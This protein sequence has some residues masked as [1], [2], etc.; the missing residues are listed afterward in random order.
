MKKRRYLQ[1]VPGEVI[2]LRRPTLPAR[3]L[4][5]LEES[6]GRA[7]AVVDPEICAQFE[8]DWTGRFRG[9]SAAV[10]RPG[11]TAEV[12]EVLSLCSAAG[13]PVVPQGGNTGLV[14]GGVPMG[15]E[16]V[17]SLRR[18]TYIGE[19]DDSTGQLTVG[20]GTTLGA[21]QQ[22]LAP[23]GLETTMDL[24]SRDSATLGGM[25]ATNAGGLQVLRNGSMRSNVTGIEV[26]LADGSVLSQLRGLP[27]DTSGYD[28]PS[29]VVGSEG[30]L[31]VITQVRLRV[32][33]A[34]DNRV[35]ALLGTASLHDAERIASRLRNEMENL[36]SAE[37]MER[38]TLLLVAARHGLPALFGDDTPWVL[39]IELSGRQAAG[40]TT[41][42]LSE[43]LT[44]KVAAEA[45][46]ITDSAIGSGGTDLQRLWSYRE[47]IPETL[48]ALGTVR[49]LDVSIP[50]GG[51]PGFVSA[52][53][54]LVGRIAPSARLHVFGHLLDGNLHLNLL[55]VSE[56]DGDGLD[57]SVLELAVSLGGSIG[58]EHGIG[59]AKSHLLHLV[60]SPEEIDLFR[61]VKRAFDPMST[62]NPGVLIPS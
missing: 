47:L 15:G 49:K 31:A 3:L 17:L 53:R 21:L 37:I 45:G 40:V 62:L 25:A 57:L 10:V 33:P 60:R 18:L 24:A 55:G 48:A 43:E 12:A 11:S 39:L 23:L 5:A 8:T 54:D 41:D 7:H 29:M 38:T 28:I 58:A 50:P 32:G 56:K 30:T 16:V 6:V 44:F 36:R 19:V 51:C 61:S 46:R 1:T 34:N 22:H 27:K 42:Q 14:G 35:V 20:A 4:E 2:G 52:A 9:I 26:V 59:R 13:V